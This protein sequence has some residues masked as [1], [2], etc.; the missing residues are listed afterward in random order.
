MMALLD[1]SY[2]SGFNNDG[3]FIGDRMKS[4]IK[5][6]LAAK[7]TE[8]KLGF[9]GNFN[10]YIPNDL[11]EEN[12]KAYIGYDNDKQTYAMYPESS[13]AQE[14]YNDSQRYGQ[15]KGR[16]KSNY[17][18]LEMWA[19]GRSTASPVPEYELELPSLNQDDNMT[20]EVIE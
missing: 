11:L 17:Q 20:V 16:F 8:E 15:Y 14:L 2:L 4:A 6:A 9:L 3:S 19:E 13:I 1:L 18:L 5:G 12:K 10:S 7:T